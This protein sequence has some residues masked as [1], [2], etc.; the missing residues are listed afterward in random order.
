MIPAWLLLGSGLGALCWRPPWLGDGRAPRAAVAT[1]MAAAAA[2]WVGS[3]A[4]LVNL[5]AAGA[6][7]VL[8]ACDALWRQ[9]LQ[10]NLA[11]W[12]TAA[13]AIWAVALPVRGSVAGLSA[14]RRSRRLLRAMTAVATGP[15]AGERRAL[16]IPGLS[17]P[18]VSLGITRPVVLLDAAF[19]EAAAEHERDIVIAH[20]NGHRRGRHAL[21]DVASRLLAGGL[22]PLPGA[23]SAQ[24]SIRRHLEALADDAAAR[25]HDRRTVGMVIA[26]I[27]LSSKPAAGLGAAG[28]CPWRVRRLVAERAC[29]SWRDRLAAGG[30]GLALAVMLL[31]VAADAAALLGPFWGKFCPL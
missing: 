6:D 18:A 21:L 29:P 20:E 17:T 31:V 23:A 19:W 26:R 12:Q 5:I 10:G 9:L 16:L 28:A 15:V 22:S 13:M 4:V 27:A 14:T 25:R 2:V 8:A 30:G 7:G 24:Q 3:F 1:L 11:W